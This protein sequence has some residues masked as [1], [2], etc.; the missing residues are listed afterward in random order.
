MKKKGFTLIELLAVI[1]ILAVI[2][3]IAT[4]L[5]MN[6]INDA[7]K[8]SFKDSAYGIKKAVELRIAE[9]NLVGEAISF[10]VD[11]TSDAINYSGEKPTS[12]W[13]HVTPDGKMELYMCNS[14]YCA[15]KTLDS[16]EIIVT[17]ISSEIETITNEITRVSELEVAEIT[18][19][20]HEIKGYTYIPNTDSNETYKGIL[21]LD[22]TD[23][24][25]KCNESNS[26]TNKQ[27]KDK[28]GV[29]T[30]T[31]TKSGCMRWFAFGNDNGNPTTAILDHNTT[32]CAEFDFNLK[33]GAPG[34]EKTTDEY[35][36]DW[37]F[38]QDVQGWDSRLQAR[39]P[40]AQEM[41]DAG[42]ITG[43]NAQ[44]STSGS[45]LGNG[46]SATQNGKYWW[47]YTNLY[48]A[49]NKNGRGN[50]NSTY[51]CIYNS[52]GSVETNK[53][54]AYWTLTPRSGSLYS[55]WGINNYGALTD[56]DISERNG[57][58]PVISLSSLKLSN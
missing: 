41:A 44:T 5:I 38:E 12:G 35:E 56:I 11:V 4:P 2:A 47:L 16:E 46:N 21:Y 48:N 25:N 45:F 17:S 57:V 18:K 50:D 54:Q 58:R 26:L 29:T 53:T 43:F 10:K 24:G 42:G 32:A 1:V 9:E 34:N 36:A 30:L 33:N 51:N 27:G 15:S 22:P 13:A 19:E 23:L 20:G 28:D 14:S 6:V 52:T 8:N 39:F 31:G 37:Y 7:R 55:V 49:E 40:N 3:L